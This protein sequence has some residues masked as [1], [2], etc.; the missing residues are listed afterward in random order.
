M[1]LEQL[2]APFPAAAIHWRA[3]NVS[4]AGDKALALAYID[5][6]D[7]MDRLDN[8]MGPT[9]WRD[10]YV[11]TPK[12]RLICTLELRIDGEW[13]G[14]SD[15]AGDTDVEGEKGAISDALKRAAVKWGIGRYLYNLGNVWAPCESYEAN[16]KKKWSKWGNGAQQVFLR[17]LHEIGASNFNPAPAT[18]TDAQLGELELLFEDL[19]VPVAEFLAAGKIANLKQLA[20][21][22]FDGAKSWIN[23]RALEKREQ[24]KA[25]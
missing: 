24:Q 10:T 11:E 8:V 12:G 6:R 16:G 4:K 21:D 18:I 7:V 5:A 22:R 23:K 2:S 1:M 25:A 3:Q 13:I 17:A 20:A 14:K 9:N 19:N 15:G